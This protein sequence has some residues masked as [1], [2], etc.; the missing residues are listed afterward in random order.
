MLAGSVPA[1]AQA[2][3]AGSLD[4]HANL[5]SRLEIWNWFQ[6]EANGDYAFVGSHYRFSA[7][8]NGRM[9]DWKLDF[10][11]PFLLG[12]PDNASAPPPQGGLGLGSNYFGANQRDRNPAM[13]FPKQAFVS[14]HGFG[15]DQSHSLKLGRFDFNEGSE[16]TPN[17]A[18]LAAVKRTR[19]QQR[20]IGSFGWSHV[21]RSY[22]GFVYAYDRPS[23]NVTV[24][25]A[26]PGRGVFQVDGWGFTKTGFGY[27]ALTL[28]FRDTA[29]VRFFG[30]YYQDW[31]PLAKTDNRPVE[32]RGNDRGNLRLWT[33]GG[34]LIAAHQSS[35]GTMDFLTWFAGQTGDWANQEHSGL[36]YAVE[37]GFQPKVLPSL[38]PWIRAGVFQSTGDGNP[39]DDEH[40]TFFQILPTPRIYARFP[41]FNLMNLEDYFA[42]L[43][44][45][46]H[47]KV[48]LRADVRSLQLSQSKDLWYAGGGAFNPWVFGYA[49]RPSFGG[50]G[51]A[52][53]FD[54][55]VDVKA[56]GNLTLSGYYAF[57][58]GKSVMRNIYPDGPNA[59][60]GYLELSYGF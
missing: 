47:A 50:K 43:I 34:H 27:A 3:N 23:A 35:A 12:L 39:N 28:P 38:K 51:L 1:L 15:P 40:R 6:G 29:E 10:A 8:H 25:A 53:L 21:G 32:I 26:I 41:F 14:L 13:V 55:S 45:R 2:N 33:G 31:R 16:V 49:G 7:G 5:R 20:L 60:F 44:L 54:L 9:A 37:G 4:Y 57:A 24:A 56:S 11:V 42:E 30:I 36:A 19:I 17:N 22:N 46:P 59:H 52:T 58:R 18:T 48:L